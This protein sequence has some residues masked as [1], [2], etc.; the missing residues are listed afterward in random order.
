MSVPIHE[1]SSESLDNTET[2]NIVNVHDPFFLWGLFEHSD[3]ALIRIIST[4]TDADRS[5]LYW[6]CHYNKHEHVCQRIL[7]DYAPVRIARDAMEKISQISKSAESKIPD[8]TQIP[9]PF[10]L[11]TSPEFLAIELRDGS[12]YSIKRTTIEIHCCRS[13]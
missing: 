2:S 11:P 9:V 5:R 1:I 6:S 3:R 8:L 10:L 12:L 4:V 7:D 13:R